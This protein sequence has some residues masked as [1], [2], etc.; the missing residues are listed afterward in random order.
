MKN[1][2]TVTV[3]GIQ[4]HGGIFN[5]ALCGRRPY[6]NV[7]TADDTA[8]STETQLPDEDILATDF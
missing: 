8:R 1:K 3:K 5:W 4:I 6:F 7:I 2:L